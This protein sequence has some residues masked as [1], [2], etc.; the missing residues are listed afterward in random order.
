[1]ITILIAL[2]R[3]L[4]KQENNLQKNKRKL[5]KWIEKKRLYRQVY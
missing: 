5:I 4:L 2:M 3:Q 1:M